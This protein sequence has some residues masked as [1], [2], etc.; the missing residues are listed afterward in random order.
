M[1]YGISPT[2]VQPRPE[3]LQISPSHQILQDSTKYLGVG[4]Q[5]SSLAWKIHIDRISKANSMLGF[6]RRNLRYCSE[7]TRANA[8]I[9]MVSTNLEYCSSVWNY[10]H[11]EQIR[12]L[13]MIQ[14]RAARH[15]TNR[16][17]TT[18]NVS[19]MLKYLQ[20]DSLESK[21]NPSL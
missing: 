17:R 14:R 1:G 2:K 21:R 5:S 18:S 9:S 6:L 4:L 19:S 20:W 8:Y 11:K 10:H 15:T 3:C 7:E 13:E 12:K 16:Y